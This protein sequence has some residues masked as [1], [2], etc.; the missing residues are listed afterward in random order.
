MTK[1]NKAVTCAAIDMGSNSTEILVAHCAPDHLD[2]VKDESTMTR[3]GDS[4]KGT[5]EIAPDKRDEA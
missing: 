4:V 5:G 1:K 3:L 2:V